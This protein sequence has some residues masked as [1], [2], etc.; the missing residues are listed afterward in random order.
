MDQISGGT[1]K[2]TWERCQ[3]SQAWELNGGS[4]GEGNS[5]SKDPGASRRLSELAI[6]NTGQSG[7]STVCVRGGCKEMRGER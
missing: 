5:M 4:P 3:Q 1:H 2:Q 7:W 6:G